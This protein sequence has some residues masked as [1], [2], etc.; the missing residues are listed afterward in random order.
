MSK[1]EVTIKDG[2]LEIEKKT[3]RYNK[4]NVQQIQIDS[5]KDG[6][7]YCSAIKITNPEDRDKIFL[8]EQIELSED[9]TR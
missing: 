5:L 9:Q 1:I 8:I 4:K 6:K 3:A 2:I 7:E